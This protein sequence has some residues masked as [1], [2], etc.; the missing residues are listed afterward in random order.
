V[1]EVESRLKGTRSQAGKA[2]R[3]REQA[4]RLRQLRTRLGLADWNKFAQEL[5][6]L[7]AHSAQLESARAAR[8]NRI[9]ELEAIVGQLDADAERMKERIRACDSDVSKLRESI[10]QCKS[11]SMVAS[12][13]MDS[14]GTELTQARRQ[15]LAVTAHSEGQDDASRDAAQ[16]LQ[17]AADAHAAALA[18][19]NKSKSI[20]NHAR[21]EL[22][23]QQEMREKLRQSG[24]T[25]LGKAAAL[26]QQEQNQRSQ[27][28]F[29]RA[30]GLTLREE[31]R[32]LNA[33]RD[34]SAIRLD[35][36]KHEECDAAQQASLCSSELVAA[37][38]RLE[39]RRR[40]ISAAHR[41][42]SAVEAEL[43]R[44]HHYD[45]LLEEQHRRVERLE[46]DLAA[47][48]A[49]ASELAFHG[50][51]ADVIRVDVDLAPLVETALG[52]R[53]RDIVLAAGGDLLAAFDGNRQLSS[54]LV[55]AR[56]D[57]RSPA[58]AVDRI[59]LSNEQGVIGR[60]DRF[61]ETDE[62]FQPLVR[63]LLGRT[64]LV[65]T[66]VT[67]Y[68]LAES[69]GKGLHFVTTAGE[70][71]SADGTIAIGPRPE[72]AGLLTWRI[73]L[74]ATRQQLTAEQARQCELQA[75][76]QSL[77]SAADRDAAEVQERL[78]V[79]APLAEHAA[80]IG[81]ERAAL[82]ERHEHLSRQI[83]ALATQEHRR[84]SELHVAEREL[85][86][87]AVERRR[88]DAEI[89]QLA[90]AVERSSAA[91]HDL[92]VR[93]AQMQELAIESQV[94]LATA[95]QRLE[96]LRAQ[97]EQLERDQQERGLALNDARERLRSA[98]VAHR[99]QELALLRHGSDHAEL[100]LRHETATIRRR[101]M[102]L[103][104]AAIRSDRARSAEQLQDVRRETD[105]LSVR[106]QQVELQRSEIRVRRDSLAQRMNE[107]FGIDLAAAAQLPQ[108]TPVETEATRAELERTIAELRSSLSLIGPVNLDAIEEL[109]ELQARYNGL[110]DQH[111]DLVEAKAAIEQLILRIN[112]ETRQLF[113]T[114]IDVV[115]GHFQEL[116]RRLFGG[117]EADLV[118]VVEDG[119]D[120]LEGGIE[121][122]A[123]PPGKDTH[124][125]SLL[126]GGEKTLTCIALLLAVF[127]SRPSPFCILD[128]VDAAL[129]EVN[130]GRF[131]TVL[132]EF[133]SSTQF[134]V[135]THSKRT[136]AGAQTLLGV[137]MQES[138]ISK[139]IAVKFEDVDEQ[140]NIHQFPA[141]KAA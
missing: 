97:A 78:A 112:G 114:T 36:L 127:R 51:V 57:W 107:D 93:C 70:Y 102:L 19:V 47:L 89:L 39:D 137:T 139:Q 28:E 3:Y 20:L 122:T 128:E 21:L 66:L 119:E 33:Q 55:F 60:A 74:Q 135:V 81:Q 92:E 68:R 11:L 121:I 56:L 85:E 134:V 53:A 5:N 96:I 49:Q 16:Q 27:C 32:H 75:E 80:T 138:G 9:A 67:G 76:I 44:L 41:Q 63:R 58:S 38:Q 133:L 8:N 132:N 126:S 123:C 4:D 91:V 118:L 65:D 71:L 103:Q 111:R 116:F 1:T 101:E 115:R 40:A 94:T 140:G 31:S 13:R 42:L 7:E 113:L 18:Q 37:Q 48:A 136:M 35:V 12:Q 99:R 83:Q 86:S 26:A 43:I 22:E 88:I 45:E 109:D 106:F 100:F 2:Q 77:E 104:E 141:R 17:F 69:I 15:L 125:I 62:L 73:D 46:Q 10:S 14:C 54:R 25:A 95:E 50:M 129:D 84:S 87:L 82:T 29:L 6:G 124:T 61:V 59:D 130:I 52:E 105:Q 24:A 120:V 90:S 131:T 34:E 117:G 98:E 64:W 110:S 23:Q 79:Y 72:A 30:A 108:T